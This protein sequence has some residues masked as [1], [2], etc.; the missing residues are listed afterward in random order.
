[1]VNYGAY[2]IQLTKTVENANQFEK[3]QATNRTIVGEYSWG[4]GN[5]NQNNTPSV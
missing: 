1:M 3:L 2:S 5:F 4:Q